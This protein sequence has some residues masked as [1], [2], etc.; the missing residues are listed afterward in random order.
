MKRV[1]V[2][3]A[4]GFGTRLKSVVS[5]LPKPMAPVNNIPFLTYLLN[6]LV[7]YGYD[8]VIL[9]AGYKYEII[10]SYFGSQ[11][12][13]IKLIY[14]IENEPLGTGG[15]ISA[16]TE[17]IDSDFFTVLNGDTFFDIDF[18][19]MEEKFLKFKSGLMVALK[20]MTSFDRYGTVEIKD[21]RILSFNEKKYCKNGL[22]N[23]GVYVISKEWLD[24]YSPGKKYSFEK[25][26]LEKV[27]GNEIID[28]YISDSY[29]ID[30]GI[31]EDYQRAAEELPG[32]QNI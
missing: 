4:G 5:D 7:K 22:I 30:I 27:I 14:S 9:A 18:G 2:I 3:L 13:N 16:A 17:F 10:E 26:I 11:Y 12:K 1:A 24:R 28:Y 8:K 25:D 6:L 19:R 23:G 21:E 15:A 31:P 32:L 20:P 29:F